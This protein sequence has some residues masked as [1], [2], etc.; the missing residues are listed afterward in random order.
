VALHIQI[1]LEPYSYLLTT[2]GKEIR[3]ALIDAF[4]VWLKV[5]DDNLEIVKSLVRRLHTASL[6]SV[7]FTPNSVVITC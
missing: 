1:L 3:S 5:P 7:S 2:P 4:N 6:L